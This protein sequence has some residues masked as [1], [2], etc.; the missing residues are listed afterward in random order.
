M[1]GRVEHLRPTQREPGG[2]NGRG[3]SVHRIVNRQQQ[4]SAVC[5]EQQAGELTGSQIRDRRW[6]GSIG[7]PL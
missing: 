6:V 5:L 3:K 2:K 4:V 1:Y 7:N